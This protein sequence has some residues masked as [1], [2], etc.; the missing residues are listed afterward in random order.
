MDT[1]SWCWR[2]AIR[3][4]VVQTSGKAERTGPVARLERPFGK[5]HP[6]ARIAS[7]VVK[8][9]PMVVNYGPRGILEAQGEFGGCRQ[10]FWWGATVPGDG[11]VFPATGANR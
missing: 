7:G 3:L 6:K 4:V 8:Q 10:V 11:R 2:W 5:S 9:G 1:K